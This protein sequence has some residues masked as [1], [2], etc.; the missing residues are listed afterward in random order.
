MERITP[1]EIKSKGYIRCEFI[2][3]K[4]REF[5]RKEVTIKEINEIIR[6]NIGCSALTL[7]R[8]LGYMVYFKM[9]IRKDDYNYEL[10]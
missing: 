10:Q 6:K 7:R 4:L 5:G 1:I 8:Y 2:L 9:I 3:N